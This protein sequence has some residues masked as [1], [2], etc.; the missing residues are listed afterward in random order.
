[1]AV[2]GIPCGRVQQGLGADALERNA[3]PGGAG[4]DHLRDDA[5]ILPHVFC[6]ISTVSTLWL[7]A[8]S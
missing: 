2:A 8:I 7:T 3:L 4:P 1:M 5:I 6:S